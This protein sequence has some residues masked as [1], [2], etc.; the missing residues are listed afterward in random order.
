MDIGYNAIRAVVYENDDIGAPEIFNSKFKNDILSLLANEDFDIKHQ[1]YLSIQY[2]LHVFKQ[3]N[4]TTIKCVATAVLRE[5]ARADDFIEFIKNKY[6]FEIEIIS[7]ENEARLTALGLITGIRH[8]DGIAADLG[9]GSL[10]LVEVSDT[11]IGELKSLELGTKVIASRNLENQ[12][13]ITG[14]IKEQY[15]NHNYENL[16][17]IGGALRFIGRL[18]IDFMNY[19]MKNLHNLEITTEDFEHYLGKLQSSSESTKAKLGKRKVNKNAIFVARAMIE[20]FKPKNIIVSTYGLK[21]GVRIESLGKKALEQDIVFEKVKYNCDY[22]NENTDFDSY[23]SIVS[24]LVATEN[25]L[26]AT[27]QL[28]IMLLKLKHKFDKT[29]NPTALSEFI[30]ASEIPFTHKNRIKLA[31]ILSY[32]SNF[33]PNQELIKISK[34]IISKEE[35]NDCQII[36]NF[37]CIAEHIDGPIFTS[38]TFSIK[39]QNY[40]LEIV[41]NE[42]LPRPIFEKICNRLKSIAYSRKMNSN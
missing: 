24:K 23:F 2:L 18:Y 21:E 14:I 22:E 31:L 11:K 40:F 8:S 28:S 27:L 12:E 30:L 19:P 6:D 16:Y 34:R 41:S 20:V 15:G 36:G 26:Y 9:G 35:H 3:L 38:P 13:S 39:I 1:T 37:L 7:G 10:E 32:S 33:K 29:L 5:H 42:I 4:V 17:L 25:E